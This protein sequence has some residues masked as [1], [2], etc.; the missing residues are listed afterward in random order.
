MSIATCPP[1]SAGLR[2]LH[3]VLI[4]TKQRWLGRALIQQQLP[5]RK[6]Q[7]YNQYGPSGPTPLIP[8]AQPANAALNIGRV[9]S[10]APTDQKFMEVLNPN[11]FA[12]DVSGY[13]LSGPV[14]LTLA[15]GEAPRV[16]CAR[17][18]LL[19]ITATVTHICCDML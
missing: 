18:A 13:K 12:V 1:C 9:S 10:T 15:T 19:W 16:A 11:P 3:A 14:Q 4:A 6:D 17:L 2:H 8:D 5:P 7:L